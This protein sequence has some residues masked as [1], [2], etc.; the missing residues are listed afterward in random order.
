MKKGFVMLVALLLLIMIVTS[1]SYAWSESYG[2]K[3][4]KGKGHS[5]K[6]GVAEPVAITMVGL[7][8][9]G[10]GIYAIKKRKKS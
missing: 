8:L 5:G 7:G 4:N 3:G 1:I 2:P 6:R 10:L 9:A